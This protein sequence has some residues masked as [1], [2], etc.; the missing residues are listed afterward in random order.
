MARA[1]FWGK[2]DT[3]ADPECKFNV[4]AKLLIECAQLPM[5][6]CFSHMSDPSTQHH[7]QRFCHSGDL[8]FGLFNSKMSY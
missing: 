3:A 2:E 1:A 6:W 7:A 8:A 4:S 5:S